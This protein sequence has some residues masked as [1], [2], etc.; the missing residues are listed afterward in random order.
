MEPFFYF[1]FNA[2]LMANSLKCTRWSEAQKMA[3]RLNAKYPT[4][5]HGWIP[6]SNKLPL[7]PEQCCGWMKNHHSG[8]TTSSSSAP[9]GMEPTGADDDDL[10]C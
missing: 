8:A 6:L 3:E 10:Y 1:A 2:D 5:R 9:L 7:T 4:T